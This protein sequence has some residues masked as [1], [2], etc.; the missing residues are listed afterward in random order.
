MDHVMALF[1][2]SLAY[3]TYTQ[4]TVSC[5]ITATCLYGFMKTISMIFPQLACFKITLYGN[6]V[7]KYKGMSKMRWLFSDSECFSILLFILEQKIQDE[8]F[9][10]ENF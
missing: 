5:A 4:S 9:I 1:S 8:K 10:V 3:E 6:N 2:A 7:S